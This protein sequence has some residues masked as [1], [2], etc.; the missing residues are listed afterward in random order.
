M[1]PM[2]AL[3]IPAQ[4]HRAVTPRPVQKPRQQ[5]AQDGNAMRTLT[6]DALH[7]HALTL[8]VI[9]NMMMRKFIPQH[10]HAMPP[11]DAL[12]A[13]Q[14]RQSL[15]RLIAQKFA[16]MELMTTLTALSIA[17]TQAALDRRGQM[18]KPVAIQ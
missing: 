9:Q 6:A 7:S 2:P 10:H 13:H 11:V 8:T 12:P 17:Q 15:I 4:L 18:E 16:T 5:H 3:L 14:P 1:F